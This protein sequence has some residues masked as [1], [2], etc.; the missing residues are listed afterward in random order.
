MG[1]PK[2]SKKTGGRQKGTLNK[3]TWNVQQMAED[4]GVNPFEIMLKIAANDWRGLGYENEFT[5]VATASGDVKSMP[6]ITLKDRLEASSKLAPFIAPT[7]KAVEVSTDGEKGF[8][9]IIEDYA[10]KDKK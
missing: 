5:F 2:G 8:R 4:L 9:V 7:K 1:K 10:S 3:F 6:Y